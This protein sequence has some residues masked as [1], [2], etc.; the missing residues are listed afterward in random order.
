MLVFALRTADPPV[1]WSED[2]NVKWRMPIEGNGSS[3]PIIWQDKLFLL[4]AVD[5]GKVDPNL[6]PPEDQPKRIFDSGCPALSSYDARGTEAEWPPRLELKHEVHQQLTVFVLVA[7]VL[8]GRQ[9][10]THHGRCGRNANV[11]EIV[12]QAAEIC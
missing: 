7:V 3:S 8:I 10:N 5:T 4:T 12:Q 9:V 6:P 2:K 11:S 1:E